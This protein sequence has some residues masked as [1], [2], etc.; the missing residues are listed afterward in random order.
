[1]RAL[2]AVS[3]LQEA[4]LLAVVAG[5]V[6]VIDSV[7][8][9]APLVRGLAALVLSLLLAGRLWLVWKLRQQLGQRRLGIES[10]GRGLILDGDSAYGKQAWSFDLGRPLLTPGPL[11]V[12]VLVFVAWV[13]AQLVPLPR[14]AGSAGVTWTRLTISAP[15]TVRGLAFLGFALLIHV[16][17]SATLDSRDARRRFIRGIAAIGLACAVLKLFR[18]AFRTALNHGFF[19]PSPVSDNIF[20]NRNQ[21]GTYML[22]AA[23]LTLG[24]VAIASRA[25]S[26]WV[27]ASPNLRRRLLGLSGPEGTSLFFALVPALACVSALIATT[28]RGALLAFACSLVFAALA[29]K[30]RFSVPQWSGLVAL[31]VIG[32]SWFGVG[33][34][35]SRFQ[36]AR[37]DAPGRTV[38]WVDTLSRMDGRWITG[39]GFNTF[40][41]AMSRT[42]AWAL[43]MGA[44]PWI[45][46]HEIALAG[47][48]GAGFRTLATGQDL[49]WY[50]EAH[51]D[52]V[53]V[54]AEAGLVGMLLVVWA[55]WR[56]LA[57]AKNDPWLLA[58][59]SGVLVHAFVDFGLHSPAV[60]ALFAAIAAMSG[61][62]R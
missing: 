29:S 15:D 27:G 33:R 56:L 2:R 22:M 3:A 44:T 47:A 12:P 43:P 25:Y 17:A 49:G 62:E 41:R 39:Y 30:K 57:A 61:R 13:L 26:S 14:V 28:S 8:N 58:A 9:V 42:T 52:Y 19:G 16:A 55:G 60:A 18:F 20:L 40:E 5:S 11:V 38:V 31:V 53:Q 6:V 34:L 7:W 59:V 45:G 24:L 10:A 50:A 51:N 32:V 37:E 1:M 46:P 54:L 4:A 48:G 21:F 36:R 23:P 35:Q